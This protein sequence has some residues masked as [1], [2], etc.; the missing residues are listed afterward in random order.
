MNQ[1][2]WEWSR[3]YYINVEISNEADKLP[4]HNI[5]ISFN[6]SSNVP[7]DVMVFV[8]YTSELTIDSDTGIIEIKVNN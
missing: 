2:Y 3:Y 6:N 7:I 4:S 5:N 1:P 8:F